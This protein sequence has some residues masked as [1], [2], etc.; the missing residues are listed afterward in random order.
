M[1]FCLVVLQG[2]QV[3]CQCDQHN[4]WGSDMSG[5]GCAVPKSVCRRRL[6]NINKHNV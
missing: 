4:V 2:W 6:V 3:M 5:T 1:S